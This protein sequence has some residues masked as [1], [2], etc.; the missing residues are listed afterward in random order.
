MSKSMNDFE[1]LAKEK[2]KR[3]WVERAQKE[4]GFAASVKPLA[5][6]RNRLRV[7]R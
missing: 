4:K 5:E 1:E 2:A 3:A 6:A 7:P